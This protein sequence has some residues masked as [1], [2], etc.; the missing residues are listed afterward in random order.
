[1]T[2]SPTKGGGGRSSRTTTSPGAGPAAAVAAWCGGEVDPAD[3]PVEQLG[4]QHLVTGRN[5][6]DDD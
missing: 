1:M 4:V 3:Q 6:D 5:C 2:V